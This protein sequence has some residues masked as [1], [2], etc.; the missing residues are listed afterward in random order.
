MMCM[1]TNRVI[2]SAGFKLQNICMRP[3]EDNRSG[4]PVT[5]SDLHN[6][7]SICFFS[8]RTHF[9]AEKQT[10]CLR[11][12]EQDALRWSTQKKHYFFWFWS[13]TLLYC[14]SSL[15][16]VSRS[17]LAVVDQLKILVTLRIVQFSISWPILTYIKYIN[18][19][20]WTTQIHFNSA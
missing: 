20:E 11:R 18:N 16:K 8:W 13:V 15:A 10:L 1:N 12:N 9:Q 5:R 19:W 3:W 6:S 4:W 2:W 14:I 7:I 17:L